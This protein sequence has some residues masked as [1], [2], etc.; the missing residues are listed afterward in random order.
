MKGPSHEPRGECHVH[1]GRALRVCRPC[2]VAM[3]T[4]AVYSARAGNQ[5]N[6]TCRNA[7]TCSVQRTCRQPATH[8]CNS[9]NFKSSS[10]LR[11]CPVITAHLFVG[12][13]GAFTPHD[14][15]EAIADDRAVSLRKGRASYF[16][17]KTHTPYAIT[18]P[19]T[20]GRRQASPRNSY[21]HPRVRALDGYGFRARRE[22]ALALHATHGH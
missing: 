14:A 18:Q 17:H 22:P 11:T 15:E 4:H 8:T 3:H 6:P 20:R 10:S 1:F 2:P 19:P 21:T 12:G 5:R 13:L 16:T 7:Y 9:T